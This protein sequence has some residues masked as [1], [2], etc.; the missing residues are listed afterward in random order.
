MVPHQEAGRQS[1]GWQR[2]LLWRIAGLLRS[3]SSWGRAGAL[4]REGG[5]CRCAGARRCACPCGGRSH[6]RRHAGH[7]VG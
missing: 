2:R 1:R 6:V 4:T 3:R 5:T 7:E